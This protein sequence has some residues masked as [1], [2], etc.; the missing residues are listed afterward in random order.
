MPSSIMSS[1][2]SRISYIMKDEDGKNKQMGVTKMLKNS[3]GDEEYTKLFLLF[4]LYYINFEG[5]Q[6]QYRIRSNIVPRV[7]EMES[8]CD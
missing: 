7:E 3:N 1:L 4:F 8:Y 6:V 2:L 5:E